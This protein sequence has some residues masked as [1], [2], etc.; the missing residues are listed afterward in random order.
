MRKVG[1]KL[2]WVSK[3]TQKAQADVPVKGVQHEEK[4]C[5]DD[6]RGRRVEA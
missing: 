5:A 3:G 2:A 4:A 1:L 6:Y